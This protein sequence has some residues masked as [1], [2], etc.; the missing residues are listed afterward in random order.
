MTVAS[1]VIAVVAVVV[2][3]GLVRVL[4]FRVDRGNAGLLV[5]GSVAIVV[6]LLV[7]PLH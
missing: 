4:G 5:V 7:W 6:V 2:M 3:L 1:M